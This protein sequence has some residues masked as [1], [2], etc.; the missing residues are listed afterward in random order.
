MVY[1]RNMES[2][3]YL[4]R[5]RRAL[6]RIPEL[7]ENE[8][9]T[10]DYIAA[11]LKALGHKYRRVKTGIICDVAGVNKTKTIALRADMDA[12]PITEKTVCDFKSE[13]GCMHAC[14]HDGHI[15]MLLEVAR[16]TSLNRPA[17]SLRLIFQPAEEGSGGAEKMIDCG[18]LNRVDEIYAFHLCP[19][20]EIGVAATNSGALFAG[21]VEFD[22]EFTGKSCH[23]ADKS[24]GNDAIGAAVNF[25]A[26][27]NGFNKNCKGNTLFHVGAFNGGKARNIVSDNVLI[28]CTLRFFDE[29]QREEV[30]MNIADCLTK[31]DSMFG[32]SHRLIVHEVYPPLI[33]STE[34]VFK[35]KK[36]F[37]ALKECEPRYTAE[38]FAFYLNRI[39]G[40]MI[41]LGIRDEKFSSPLHSNTF[42]F[43]ES[44]L[45]TG[46]EIY[47]KIIF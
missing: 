29:N 12:L 41:W 33:N 24:D 31:G 32:T 43:D 13:N 11:E 16:L 15:S 14:G 23:C 18:A 17:N 28:C 22:V 20:L 2:L 26:S 5:V 7:S 47:K 40:C 38:D 30:L 4:T 27:A 44:A 46:V 25:C 35:I 10:A 39:K 37:P 45:L 8:F 36:L 1:N 3:Q 6:H 21:A 34:A 9:K 19:E 42:G